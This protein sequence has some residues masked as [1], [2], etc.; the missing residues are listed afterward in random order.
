MF[1]VL[2]VSWAHFSNEMDATKDLVKWMLQLDT[3]EGPAW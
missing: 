2:E 1:E 3:R